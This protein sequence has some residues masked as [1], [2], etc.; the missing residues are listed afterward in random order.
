M[1]FIT[2]KLIAHVN[3]W[4]GLRFFLNSGIVI[5]KLCWFQICP[6][7]LSMGIRSKVIINL[8][9]LSISCNLKLKKMAKIFYFDD[10]KYLNSKQYFR[11]QKVKN[12]ALK[13]TSKVV[14]E[15]LLRSYENLKFFIKFGNK[16]TLLWLYLVNYE[17]KVHFVKN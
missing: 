7:K 2:N 4:V 8:S 14:L 9:F 12:Y 10:E 1:F 6:Q 5:S 17:N 13:I 11:S 15:I 3:G 16:S